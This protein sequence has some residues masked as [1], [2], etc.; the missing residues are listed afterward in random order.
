MTRAFLLGAVAAVA[1]VACRGAAWAGSVQLDARVRGDTGGAIERA[2]ASVLEENGV[3]TPIRVKGAVR[4]KRRKVTIVLTVRDDDGRVL[5]RLRVHASSRKEAVARV[6]RQLW[7]RIEASLESLE[8]AD[9]TPAVA[10]VDSATDGE[11]NG[12]GDGPDSAAGDVEVTRSGSPATGR[13]RLAP[14]ISISIG[15]EIVGR[16][17]SYRDDLF[18]Q[19]RRYD[20]GGTAS[21]AGAG[22]VFPLAGRGGW[23]SA[24]GGAARFSY[25]PSFGSDATNGEAY[26]SSASSYAIGARV[27]RELE[28]D[29]TGVVLTGAFDVGGQ[30]FSV[31]SMTSELDSGVPDVSYRYLRPGASARVA[32]L[33]RYAVELAL[34]YRHVLD[35]GE[36]GDAEHFP[37]LGVRGVDVEGSIAV[38]LRRGFDLRA[39]A[40][41]EQYGYDLD[42]QPGDP[43]VAGGATDRYPRLF[44]RIGWAR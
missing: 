31:D 34:G 4:A 43:M 8:A 23:R 21:F 19:L 32:I 2:I 20:L 17:F 30:S 33:G 7:E 22:E 27:R 41:L 26:T 1:I 25:T 15:P 40:A 36:I 10:A 39:G 18:D 37:R 28:V 38:P 42:P 35:V 5:G 24:L 11:G 16:H 3:D 14:R 13:A 12:G 9:E 44:L 29:G 6:E